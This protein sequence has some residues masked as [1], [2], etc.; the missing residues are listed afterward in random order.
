MM[1]WV[2]PGETAPDIPENAKFTDTGPWRPV[3]DPRGNT[4]G[5]FVGEG[6]A[7]SLRTPDVPAGPEPPQL[8]TAGPVPA[9]PPPPAPQWKYVS[10]AGGTWKHYLTPDG[11]NLWIAPGQTGPETP[12]ITNQSGGSFVA[13]TSPDGKVAYVWHPTSWGIR[14]PQGPGITPP[15][16]PTP[17]SQPAPYQPPVTPPSLSI[18]A[19]Q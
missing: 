2:P 18:P 5:V 11:M 10:G 7:P 14:T 15:T 3:V 9:P 17:P 12:D 1:W 19:S 6:A 16:V 13:T 8:K 4:V